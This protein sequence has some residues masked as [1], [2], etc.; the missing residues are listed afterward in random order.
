M[1]NLMMGDCLERMKEIESG[2][3]DLIACD[4]P[5]GTVKGMAES[6]SIKHGM[7]NIDK[8]MHIEVKSY[9]EIDK[10]KVIV[11]DNGK[12]FDTS[13][14]S[15]INRGIGLKNTIERCEKMFGKNQIEIISEHGKG[16]TTIFTFP[17]INKE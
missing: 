3:I 1:I 12:G 11:S 10:L 14:E 16:T 5:Y 8:P 9:I 7:K 15:F 4:L 17:I 2:S 6:D 13:D